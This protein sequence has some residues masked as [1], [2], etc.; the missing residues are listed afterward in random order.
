MYIII[1]WRF[2]NFQ[3]T[4]YGSAYAQQIYFVVE[5]AHQKQHNKDTMKIFT[6]I[7]DK[8]SLPFYTKI[9][10]WLNQ[11]QNKTYTVTIDYLFIYGTTYINK[12]VIS[13]NINL[14][15]PKRYR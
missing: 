9:T 14:E 12:L 3:D 2:I 8:E 7:I 13:Q 11:N 1:T 5:T 15:K 6:T 10:G 4:I